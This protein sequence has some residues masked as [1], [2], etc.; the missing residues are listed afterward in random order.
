MN[1]VINRLFEKKISASGLAVFRVFFSLN[2]LFEVFRVF[3][4]RQLYFDPMPFIESASPL[5]TIS[6]L[7]W[8]LVLL[9]LSAGLFTKVMSVLNY[10]LALLVIDYFSLLEYHMNHIYIGMSFMMIFLP[11]NRF[12]SVDSLLAKRADKNKVIQKRK[13]AAL[14]YYL[15]LLLG[16]GFVYLDSIFFKFKS[17]MWV[18]GLGMWLPASMPQ[19]TILKDQWLLNQKWLIVS[20]G[21]LTMC[22]EL[23][24]PFT[25]FIKRFRIPLLI[26]GIG[27]HIGI[28]LEFPIPYFA[29]GYIAIYILMV[30]VSLW[31]RIAQKLEKPTLQ[32]NLAGITSEE[33]INPV[34]SKK[35]L[36]ILMLCVLLLQ[37]NSTFNFPLSEGIVNR[38]EA[39]FPSAQPVLGELLQIKKKVR[40]FSV[41]AL[42]ITQHGV[43]VDEHFAGL[44]N[45]YSVKYGET[46]LPF[47]DVD[48]MPDTY[49]QGGTWIDFNYRVNGINVQQRMGTLEKGLKRYTAFWAKKQGVSLDNTEFSIIKKKVKPIFLWEKDLLKNNMNTP[50][51]KVGTMTWSKE[52]AYITFEEDLK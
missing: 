17:D 31:D 6:L 10:A 40:R 16:I 11:L 23:I 13:V 20:L 29:L 41:K 50:W 45:L 35:A 24:F 9:C 19:A 49:L 46:Y 18:G 38:I 39:S 42:G 34:R 44:N 30:P 48:G 25:F 26:V 3:R 28:L 33:K 37:L 5:I 43:F 51:E 15:P 27:L 8:M 12:F 32:T 1:K 36:V 14:Y 21:Y 22:F 7:V 52:K 2:L 47:Y 4:Y